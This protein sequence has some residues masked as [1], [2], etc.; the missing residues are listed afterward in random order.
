[1]NKALCLVVVVLFSLLAAAPLQAAPKLYQVTGPVLAITDTT[2]VVQKGDEKWEI[3]KDAATK[4]G[5]PLKVGDK[6][7]IQY[8]MTAASVEIKK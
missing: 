1:M 5:G 8:R 7:T 2:I 3:A 6:V 4:L